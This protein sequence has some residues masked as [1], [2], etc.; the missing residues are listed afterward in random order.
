MNHSGVYLGLEMGSTRIKA[1]GIDSKHRPVVTGDHTWQSSFENGVWT[2]DLDEVWSGIRAAVS[3]MQAKDDIVGMGVSGMMHGYLA[4]DKDWRLLTPFRTWQNTSTGQAAEEL[5]DLFRFNVPQRWSIAHLYQAMLNAETHVKDIAHITTLAGYV[6]VSL[7]GVNA[8]GI[9]EASGIF[10]IDSNTL[11]YDEAMLE[12]FDTLAKGMHCPW[13]IKDL[14]PRVLQAGDAAGFLTPEG[15]SRLDGQ[16]NA[17]IPFAPAEGD[18]GTGMAATNAVAARTGNV[19]AGTSIFAMVV[20]EHALKNVHPEIDVLTTPGGKPVAM[21]H[22]NNGTNDMNAWVKVL[23]ETAALFGVEVSPGEAFTKLYQKSL[24][25]AADAGG[26]LVFNYLAGEGVTSFNEGRP[27]VIRTPGSSF[28]LANF[29]RAQLYSSMATLRIGM[30]LLSQ[31]NVAIDRLMGHGGLFKTPIVAQRYL[32]AACNVPVTCMETAGEGGPYG[33]ALLTAFM[34]NKKNGE[35]LESYL[36]DSVFADAE[37]T[38]LAPEA[39]DV[40]GFNSFL[41]YYKRGLAVERS[42][43]ENL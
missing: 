22:C 9:G 23:R 38:T 26:I 4:F 5:T 39:P 36:A 2:Y 17:G 29:L 20:L 8:V 21:V 32:A 33:M 37:S 16:L 3:Q 11:D 6:H 31:E 18:A 27:M 24:E 13:H 14:L 12:K 43:V 7:T 35:T 30:D 41:E 25:G 1:V 40:Q 42:A 19:S 15:A 10:P 34:L 28:T